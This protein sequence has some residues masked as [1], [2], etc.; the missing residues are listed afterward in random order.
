MSGGPVEADHQCDA[1][2]EEHLRVVVREAE[3]GD[4]AVE[5]RLKELA[6]VG[7]AETRI[8][9]DVESAPE[10][11]LKRRVEP[12][13]DVGRLDG[14]SASLPRGSRTGG[15]LRGGERGQTHSV[16]EDVP[17]SDV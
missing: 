6:L 9:V 14:G 3:R 4:G 10:P 16:R 8:A 5:L 13:V 7:Q 17:A 1:E 15:H 11:A 2:R 12:A